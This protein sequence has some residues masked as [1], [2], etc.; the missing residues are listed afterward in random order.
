MP[1]P[2]SANAF[3]LNPASPQA[4]AIAH[5][6]FGT[7]IFLGAILALV[8]FLIIYALVRYRDRPGAS[9]PRQSFG[10]RKLETIWTLVPIASLAVLT[11]FTAWTMHSG[12]PPDPG[13]NPDLVI[14]AHQW[15]WELN[16]IK[17]GAVA[18]NEIHLPVGQRFLVELRSSDVIHD[19]WAPQLARKIDVVPGH[20]NHIWLEASKAGTYL[21]VCAEFCGDEHAWM[22]FQ[23]IAQPAD[24]FAT[25]LNDQVH[26][27]TEPNS[28]EAQR[29]QQLFIQRTCANCHTVAGTAA[30]Q[31]VGPDLTHIASRLMLAGGA[32]ENTPKNLALWLHD[33]NIFKPASHMPNLQLSKKDVGELLAYL[34]TLR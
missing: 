9:D 7:L 20:P 1:A 6:F 5:L 12:D 17:S 25:W 13:E 23:V 26:I 14:V 34:E 11:V 4:T 15:W 24:Q 18:A 16:Y 8:T 29:G 10:S 19:F 22:R 27:P 3:T 32:T 30:N 33:P 28:A 31:R 21:G 2:Y